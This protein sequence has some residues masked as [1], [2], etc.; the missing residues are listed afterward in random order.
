M[1]SIIERHKKNFI[2]QFIVCSKKIANILVLTSRRTIQWVVPTRTHPFLTPSTKM[3]SHA[4]I[5]VSDLLREQRAILKQ[6]EELQA[7]HAFLQAIIKKYSPSAQGNIGNK[8]DTYRSRRGLTTQREL[9]IDML[10]SSQYGLSN[11]EIFNKLKAVGKVSTRPT[12]HA[13]LSRWHKDITTPI[14]R[15]RVGFY[16]YQKS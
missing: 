2:V 9:V 15:Q 6:I 16:R 7:R 4:S 13:Q 3:S 12:L 11:E 5:P 1:N 14:V 8:P 10:R